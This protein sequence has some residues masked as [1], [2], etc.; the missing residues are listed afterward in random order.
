MERRSFL[1]SIGGAIALSGQGALSPLGSSIQTPSG[2]GIR[3]RW[4]ALLGR[5]ADPLLVALAED[6]LKTVMPVETRSRHLVDG[7]R[8]FTHLEGFGRLFCGMASW[9][10]MPPDASAEGAIRAR[11][12]ELTIRSI[13]HAVGRGSK[14]RMNFSDGGQPVVDAAFFA[15][16]LL[17]APRLWQQLDATTQANV[18]AALRETRAIKPYFNNWLLF[19]A[20]IEVFFMSIGE[21]YDPMRIDYALRQHEQWYKGDGI[22]GDGPEFHWDNY[23]SYV[24]QPFMRTIL[25]VVAPKDNAYVPLQDKFSQIAGRYAVVQQRLIAPDGSFP[26]IGRSLAYRCGAFHHLAAEAW[27]KVLPKEL[28]PSQARSALNAVIGRTLSHPSNFDDQGWLRIGLSGHQPHIAEE[29]ISTGSLYLCAT[30]FL[31]LGLPPEDEFWSSPAVATTAER[32]WSGEDIEPDSAL[33]L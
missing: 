16:A 23:N 14:D 4:T 12:I 27:L 15:L 7:R 26:P 3:A 22:F 6:R 5:I 31:P 33:K 30:A 9:L 21:A 17:R 28:P 1:G 8:K 20:M 25:S 10:Q 19:S 32:V 24:I 18:V 13:G 29:Y 2:L 11:Y